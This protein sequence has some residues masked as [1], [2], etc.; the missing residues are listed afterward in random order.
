MVV[1]SGTVFYFTRQSIM[2]ERYGMG[3]RALYIA[4]SGANWGLLFVKSYEGEKKEK[5]V[6]FSVGKGKA[7]VFVKREQSGKREVWQIRS[8]GI[9]EVSQTVRYV[10]LTVSVAKEMKA[11]KVENV[12]SDRF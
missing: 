12:S 8:R 4:E 11:V 3:L 2:N 1:M 7:E 5:Q 10:T 9:D 6:T